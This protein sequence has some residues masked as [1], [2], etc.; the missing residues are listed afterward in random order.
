MSTF[1]IVD[2]SITGLMAFWLLFYIFFRKFFLKIHL[3]WSLVFLQIINCVFEA[4][5][6]DW[7]VLS[8]SCCFLVLFTWFLAMSYKEAGQA[9]MKEVYRDLFKMLAS[10]NRSKTPAE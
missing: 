6:H 4:V 10:A 5:Q 8:F 9:E 7:L 1:E 2:Y 3:I